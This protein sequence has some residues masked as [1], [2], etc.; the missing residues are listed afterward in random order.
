[1]CSAAVVIVANSLVYNVQDLFEKA[2]ALWKAH[3]IV[4]AVVSDFWRRT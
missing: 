1:M 2:S 4:E 3:A